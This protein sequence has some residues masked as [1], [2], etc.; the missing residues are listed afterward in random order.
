MENRIND[1]TVKENVF[2]K[3]LHK[4]C[5]ERTNYVCEELEKWKVMECRLRDK[6]DRQ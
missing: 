5:Q 6:I 3:N 1:E 2:R 4:M